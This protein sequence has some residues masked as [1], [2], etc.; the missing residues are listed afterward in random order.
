VTTAGGGGGGGGGGTLEEVVDGAVTTDV[1]VSPA[2]VGAAEDVL[3][4]AEEAMAP[5]VD[6]P[7]PGAVHPASTATAATVSGIRTRPVS[8]R[9][10]REP[11]A[12]KKFEPLELETP[13]LETLELETLG[14]N[15]P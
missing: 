11:I 12:P 14:S 6:P 13:E 8:R 3:A 2:L 9:R 15:G 5:R 10:R 4:C 7:G 1:A